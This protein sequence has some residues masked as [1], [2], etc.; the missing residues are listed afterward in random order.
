MENK[1][2]FEHNKIKVIGYV[3]DCKLDSFGVVFV[4][5]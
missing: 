1:I 4:I 5:Y 2:N 3:E